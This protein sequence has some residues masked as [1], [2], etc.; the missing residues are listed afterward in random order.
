M[1]LYQLVIF[2][3]FLLAICCAEDNAGGSDGE[4][5]AVF[6]DTA[7]TVAQNFVIYEGAGVARTIA[8]HIFQS[9]FL[10]A[11]YIDDAMVHIYTWIYGLDR[12]VDA[13]VL[14]VSSDDVV[15]HLQRDDL[16]VGE[17]VFDDY[18]GAY[19]I[20]VGI[21]IKLLFLAGFAELGYA[22]TDA[23]LLVAV[24]ANEDQALACLVFGL[25]ER[26]EIIAF[27]ATYSFNIYFFSFLNFFLYIIM[28]TTPLPL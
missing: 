21:F 10:V 2:P 7:L 18:D 22:H 6:D 14:H 23:K 5:G 3:L 12:A 17:Y 16:L 1:V 20:F 8:E 28:Y 25:V 24:R 15:A 26:D 27:R 13:T 11:A 19:A 9:S 4:E